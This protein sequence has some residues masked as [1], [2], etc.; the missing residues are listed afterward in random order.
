MHS[1]VDVDNWRKQ[2]YEGMREGESSQTLVVPN[3]TTLHSHARTTSLILLVGSTALPF[4]KFFI[5][6]SWKRYL[7]SQLVNNEF[8]LPNPIPFNV[9]R[10]GII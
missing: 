7:L 6:A 3:C 1:W 8:S 10:V 2:S 4:Q 5:P 9:G